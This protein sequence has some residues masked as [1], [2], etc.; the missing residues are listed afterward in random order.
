MT[1]PRWDR[2]LQ[3]AICNKHY[4]LQT[5]SQAKT[6]GKMGTGAKAG[7]K[8]SGKVPMTSERAKQTKDAAGKKRSGTNTGPGQPD[9][10]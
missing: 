8:T 9:P 1:V 6:P 3:E 10:D 7:G 4:K 2:A 5:S